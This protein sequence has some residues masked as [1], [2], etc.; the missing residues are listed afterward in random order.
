MRFFFYGTLVDDA[1]R[2][3]VLGRMAGR[4]RA[5]PAV[6]DGYEARLA[7][8]RRYPLAVR[9]RGA[10]LPGIVMTLPRRAAARIVAYEG[11]EYRCVHRPAR[12][13]N[14]AITTVAVF[15]PKAHA[16]VSRTAWSLERWREGTRR[17]R[18]VF[19]RAWLQVS[20]DGSGGRSN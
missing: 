16:R 2:R 15:L 13:A 14:N 9:R 17:R 4:L 6:L 8:G 3:V 7:A 20:G 10:V 18:R 12:I 19:R 11:P 1:L 5:F